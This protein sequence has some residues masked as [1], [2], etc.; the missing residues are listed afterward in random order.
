MEDLIKALQIFCEYGNPYC[1]THCEHDRLTVCIDPEI[2]S[3]E[4][5]VKLDKLN[6]YPDEDC[7]MS[8]RFGSA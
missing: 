4:D 8:Y 6:F 2:V 1:P 3:D 7:F 5:K